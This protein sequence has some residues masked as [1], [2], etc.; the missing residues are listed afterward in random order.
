MVDIQA[1]DIVKTVVSAEQPKAVVTQAPPPTGG[2]RPSPT[3]SPERNKTVDHITLAT[4]G[5]SRKHLLGDETTRGILEQVHEL[6]LNNGYRLRAKEENNFL[7][8]PVKAESMFG[9]G[10]AGERGEEDVSFYSGALA[11]YGEINWVVPASSFVANGSMIE[12]RQNLTASYGKENGLSGR[13][14]EFGYYSPLGRALREVKNA[15]DGLEVLHNMTENIGITGV[16][17]A[18]A[19]R[20]FLYNYGRFSD[21]QPREGYDDYLIRKIGKP[22]GEISVGEF[23]SFLATETTSHQQTERE[24]MQL[25]E[26]RREQSGVNLHNPFAICFVPDSELAAIHAKIDATVN[27]TDEQRS[28]MKKQYVPY[29]T[30]EENDGT[31]E[32][33]QRIQALTDNPRAYAQLVFE[34]VRSYYGDHTLQIDDVMDM[35]AQGEDNITSIHFKQAD[36]NELFSYSEN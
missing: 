29:K 31:L 9:G 15:Y 32:L 4:H 20:G 30:T 27:L 3:R 28:F 12:M 7:K 11:G 23:K 10:G 35:I 18:E 26:V 19:I 6:G 21:Q 5:Q 34:N 1:P 14:G 36:N 24:N 17:N 25:A 33:S 8:I 13:T 2:E 16:I 22:A